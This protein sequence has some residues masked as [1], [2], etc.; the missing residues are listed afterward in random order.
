MNAILIPIPRKDKLHICDNWRGILI[1][2]VME[3]VVE[4]MIQNRLKVLAE[5]ELPE[6]HCGFREG[7]GC[8]DMI[9]TIR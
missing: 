8:A 3:K 7:C 4:R 9:L 6:S 5:R 2:E 1:L